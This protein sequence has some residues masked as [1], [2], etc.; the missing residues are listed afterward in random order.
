VLPG[1]VAEMKQPSEEFVVVAIGASSSSTFD[2][3]LSDRRIIGPIFTTGTA[4]KK[5]DREVASALSRTA[6][7]SCVCH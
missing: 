5:L 2:E 1:K 6:I 7:A 3:Q 4:K